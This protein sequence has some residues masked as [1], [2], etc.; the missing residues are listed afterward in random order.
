YLRLP[1]LVEGGGHADALQARLAAAGI[2]AGRM[3]RRT[4]D[5]I[6][7]DLSAPSYPGARQV[8]CGLI[9]LPT[10][11]SVTLPD[12]ERGVDLLRQ[13][14]AHQSPSLSPPPYLRLVCYPLVGCF[15]RCYPDTDASGRALPPVGRRAYASSQRQIRGKDSTMKKQQGLQTQVMRLGRD[16]AEWL[17]SLSDDDI[18]QLESHI[19][20]L[21][22]KL[23]KEYG[24]SAAR[25]RRE[26]AAYLD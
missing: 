16:V 22:G 23:Q 6:F 18:K 1:L 4:L 9:T 14:L 11:H 26:L 15:I 25:A 8:A 20:R 24:W 19:D 3:Y 10:S 5:A 17:A 12:I 21:L 13:N 2:G 7:P